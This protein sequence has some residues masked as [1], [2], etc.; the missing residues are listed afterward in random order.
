LDEFG[1]IDHADRDFLN[2]I[3][4]NLR[5]ATPSQNCMNT[6]PRSVVETGAKKGVRKI[7][8]RWRARIQVGRVRSHLGT[9][10]TEDGAFAA[11]VMAAE[12]L[13]G[14]FMRV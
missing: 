9:F 14:E 8:G 4:G 5:E 7:Y 11:Y 13:H 10:D 1:L 2:N 3:P 6:L 12:R